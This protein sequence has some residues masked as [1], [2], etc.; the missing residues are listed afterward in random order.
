MCPIIIAPAK[1]H[2]ENENDKGNY[3]EHKRVDKNKSSTHRPKTYKDNSQ[4]IMNCN[5]KQTLMIQRKKACS[6]ALNPCV[7]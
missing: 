6:S 7:P 2:T 4:Y 3:K 1:G 5:R